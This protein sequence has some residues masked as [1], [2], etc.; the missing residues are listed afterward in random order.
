[1]VTLLNT[2]IAPGPV[3]KLVLSQHSHIHYRVVCLVHYW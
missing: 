2:L 1:M 3:L